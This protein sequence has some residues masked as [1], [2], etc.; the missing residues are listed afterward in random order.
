MTEQTATIQAEY[1]VVTCSCGM[2]P[3]DQA[4]HRTSASAWQA[5]AKHVEL[6]PSKCQPSMFRDT[7]PAGLVARI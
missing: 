5:A 3:L 7:A 6:N 4:T 2:F 1:V